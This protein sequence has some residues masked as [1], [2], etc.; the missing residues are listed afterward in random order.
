MFSSKA[1]KNNVIGKCYKE[2]MIDFADKDGARVDEWVFG[3]VEEFFKTA[4]SNST[5]HSKLKSD[6]LVFF[7]HLLGKAIRIDK[8]IYIAKA[9][10][11]ASPMPLF[12]IS[13]II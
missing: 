4:R 12:L 9:V 11:L 7:L 5:L 6:K 3:E 1:L 10:I 2:D 13:V 8:G